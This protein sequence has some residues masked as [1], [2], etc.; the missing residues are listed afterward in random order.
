MRSWHDAQVRT[1]F[2]HANSTD[3][4]GP[5][6]PGPVVAAVLVRAKGWVEIG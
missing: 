5:G 6:D 1:R 2:A 3:D 4:C